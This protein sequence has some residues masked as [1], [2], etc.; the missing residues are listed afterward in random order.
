LTGLGEPALLLTGVAPANGGDHDDG[1]LTA[2]K[3]A[4]LDLRAA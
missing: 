2:S 1:L 3:I 4:G